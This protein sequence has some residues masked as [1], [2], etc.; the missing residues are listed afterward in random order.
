[1]ESKQQ[2][3]IGDALKHLTDELVQAYKSLAGARMDLWAAEKEIAQERAAKQ[4]KIYQLLNLEREHS[5]LKEQT[6]TVRKESGPSWQPLSKLPVCKEGVYVLLYEW[7]GDARSSNEPYQQVELG[8][9]N[10]KE[11]YFVSSEDG[12]DFDLPGSAKLIAFVDLKFAPHLPRIEV[13]Q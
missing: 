4:D 12:S 9:W 3:S 13:G 5:R 10:D 7:P 2:A 6:Q 1:M 11:G 8:V